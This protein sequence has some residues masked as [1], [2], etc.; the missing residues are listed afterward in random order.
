MIFDLEDIVYLLIAIPMV[1]SIWV[2]LIWFILS[3]LGF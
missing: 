1:I 2:L 3:M